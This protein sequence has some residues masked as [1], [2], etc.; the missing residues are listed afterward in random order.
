MNGVQRVKAASF[1]SLPLEA[2]AVLAG[3]PLQDVT[4]VELPGGGA[5]RSVADVRALLPRGPAAAGGR[6]TRALFA[7]RGFMGRLLR[8]DTRADRR[9]GDSFESRV[10][11]HV[12]R[13]SSV[14]PGTRSGPLSTLYEL[15]DEIV[16]EA[17]GG[18]A[19]A[20]LT[21]AL[22][23]AQSGYRL[24]CGVHVIPSSRLTPLYMLLIEPFRRYIVYPSVLG[25][26]RD[27]WQARYAH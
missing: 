12:A 1:Q 17:R 21:I 15:R 18:L 10:P 16:F 9:A 11:E 6:L 23:P 3:V 13:R 22:Q 7:L 8:W 5:G 26:L 25:G 4:M 27:A 2:H 19:H 20:F 24:Y 14:A